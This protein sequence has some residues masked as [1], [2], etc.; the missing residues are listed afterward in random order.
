MI[1]LDFNSVFITSILSQP[2]DI[3]NL[4]VVRHIILSR[5]LD[6]RQ[7]FKEYGQITICCDGKGRSWRADVLEY[8]KARRKDRR[9][10]DTK[11]DWN[12]LHDSLNQIRLELIDKL[13]YPVVCVPNVEGD[14]VVATLVKCYHNDLKNIKTVSIEQEDFNYIK[15]YNGDDITTYPIPLNNKKTLIISSDK[16]FLQLQIYKGLKQYSPYIKDFLNE[17]DP[18][19][20]LKIKILRGDD[21][22]DIPNIL[23]DSDTFV[24]PNKRQKPLREKT[25][26]KLLE[27]PFKDLEP[28][29]QYNYLRNK[30]LIDL[31]DEIPNNITMT[32]LKEY[33]N[34]LEY[35]NKIKRKKLLPYFME[36]NLKLFLRDLSKF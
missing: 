32:I 28:Q 2:D 10:I 21:G 20:F 12:A 30:K 29:L 24:V 1:F 26:L 4:N 13:P 35:K 7:M 16:D 3:S 33:F 9:K 15:F 25:L 27:T 8:Y 31:I 6:Y 17:N 11:I 23:S 14:D 5:I 34:Q 36:N 22:D 18:S 19:S